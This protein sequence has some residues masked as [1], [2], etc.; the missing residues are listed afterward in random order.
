MSNTNLSIAVLVGL[1]AGQLFADGERPFKVVNTLRVGYS[2]NL[3]REKDSIAEEGTFVTDTVDLAFSAALSDRTDLVVKSRFDLLS[4]QRENNL[5]PS[6]YAL[7]NHSVSPRLLLGLYDS[8]RSSNRSGPEAGVSGTKGTRYDYFVNTVGVSADYV[9]TGKDRLN[10][11]ADY[12]IMRSDDVI[13]YNDYTT[14][15]GGVSWQ[16]ELNPQRTFFALK[17]RQGHTEYDEM[18][19]TNSFDQTDVS[20]ELRHTINQQWQARGEIGGSYVQRETE[21]TLNPLLNLGLVYSPSPRTR[22]SGDF[23]MKHQESTTFSFIGQDSAE[24]RFAA[25][26]DLTA[27]LTAKATARFA[28]IEY[29]SKDSAN[30]GSSDS[31]ERMDLDFRMTYKLNR[32][33]FLEAGIVHREATRDSGNEWAENRVDIGWRI[34]LN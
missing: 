33:N 5:N 11:S 23:S 34:E 29:D 25:Q 26:H 24:L 7:L 32:M 18:T 14:V 27:R 4:D 19:S 21:D 13:S 10:A 31:E 1:A 12:T 6:L 20:A 30:G 17:L 3:Y 15:G 16:R 2:D 22:L 28:N 8:F 9:L